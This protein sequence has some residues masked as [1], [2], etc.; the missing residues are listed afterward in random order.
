M[1]YFVQRSL[2]GRTLVAEIYQ[3]RK[4]V[5]ENDISRQLVSRDRRGRAGRGGKLTDLVPKLDNQPLGGLSTNAGY[6]GQPTEIVRSNSGNYLVRAH[7]AQH[8]DA[9]FCADAL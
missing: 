8:R 2:G 6:R 3:S 5:I 1:Y 7:S 4:C 9:R